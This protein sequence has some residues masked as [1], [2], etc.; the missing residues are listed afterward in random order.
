MRKLLF[1]LPILLLSSCASLDFQIRALQTASMYDGIYYNKSTRV[2]SNFVFFQPNYYND[3]WWNYSIN[4]PYQLYGYNGL[5]LTYNWR[6]NRWNSNQWLLQ[7]HYNQFQIQ[8]IIPV[9]VIQNRG[10][11]NQRPIIRTP[12]PRVIVP[13]Q[14]R[15]VYVPRHVEPRRVETPIRG[16]NNQTPPRVQQPQPRVQQPTR[17]PQ[18]TQSPVRQQQT[19]K[20]TRGGI[21]IKQ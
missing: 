6:Y 19:P 1:L 17:T 8:P 15:R 16:R 10:R 9:R 7:P 2:N 20:T 11:N 21:D 12:R 13:Q 18:R 5:G 14:P 4:Y 3:F